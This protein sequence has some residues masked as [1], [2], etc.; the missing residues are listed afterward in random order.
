MTKFVST[1]T[2]GAGHSMI[3]QKPMT[4]D[5]FEKAKPKKEDINSY[6]LF[7]GS[8]NYN[9][10]FD[11]KPEPPKDEEFIQP[12]FRLL[13]NCI[14]AKN[15]MPTEFSEKVLKDSVSLII[16]QT[17]NCDHETDIANAIGSVADAYW[18][19][20]Y[21]A[22]GVNIPGGI[23]G[24]LKIDAKAN[25]RIARGI[26]MDPPSVHSNSVTVQFEWEPSHYKDD[27]NAFWSHFGETHADGTIVRRIATKIVAYRETSL[28]SHGAD[29]F[30]QKVDN[31]GHIVNPQ[32]SKNVYYGGNSLSEDM[33]KQMANECSEVFD[34][35]EAEA[36]FSEKP[37]QRIINPI[38]H[39]TMPDLM[40]L[41]ELYKILNLELKEGENPTEAKVREVVTSLL[42]EVSDLREKASNH[43]N[44]VNSLNDEIGKLNDQL[45]A[46]TSLVEYANKSIAS[47]RE[48]ALENYKKLN[49]EKADQAILDLIA[50]ES[51]T[52]SVL[53]SL[54]NSYTQQ[55]E[56][57]FPMKCAKCGSHEISRASSVAEEENK[58]EE[59]HSV[60]D[61]INSILEKRKK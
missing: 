41:T 12:T 9:T 49:G 3:Y 23:N 18:Q 53:A 21:K 55:L 27:I 14:V 33:V 43:E 38:N 42:S 28:V 15:Y 34:W 48:S 56:E 1:L 51:T 52:P 29:P 60:A 31:N 57:R 54:N 39:N 25:P 47:L 6:G 32:Y 7:G 20:A 19:D 40:S 50:N 24:I 16:G 36:S 46:Q 45:K 61:A 30:A 5:F 37:T 4:A 35:K 13:S 26:L 8:N 58:D 10:Y 11:I 44:V 59:V 22:N 17:V 2:L